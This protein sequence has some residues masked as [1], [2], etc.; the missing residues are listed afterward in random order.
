M[1]LV[2]FS[3]ALSESIIDL[4]IPE[5]WNDGE[6]GPLAAGQVKSSG[7]RLFMPAEIFNVDE[8]Y[9]YFY[10]RFTGPVIRIKST[11]TWTV[12]PTSKQNMFPRL[13]PSSILRWKSLL[14]VTNQRRSGNVQPARLWCK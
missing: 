4:I 14:L 10:Q 7:K 6:G 11:Q 2:D 8:S 13:S 5:F 1:I 9:R 3:V 12:K